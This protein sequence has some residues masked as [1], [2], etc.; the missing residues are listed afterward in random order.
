H[1]GCGNPAAGG[2]RDEGAHHP[3]LEDA[4]SAGSDGLAGGGPALDA[5]QAAGEALED[6]PLVNPRRGA[7]LARAGAGAVDA[8]IMDGAGLRAGAVAT[9]TGVRHPVALARVVMEETPHVLLAGAGAERLA[10]SHALEQCEPDWFVTERQRERW[11]AAK[12]T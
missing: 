1:G 12:G 8:S 11:M 3:G 2:V 9:V 4:L 10:I 5:G 7:V 6:C